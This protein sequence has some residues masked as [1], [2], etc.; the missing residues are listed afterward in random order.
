[1]KKLQKGLAYLN[2]IS[3]NSYVNSY[4]GAIFINLSEKISKKDIKYMTK[5]GFKYDYDTFF[6]PIKLS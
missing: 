4:H 3:D 6:L 5:L 2:Y 1:M